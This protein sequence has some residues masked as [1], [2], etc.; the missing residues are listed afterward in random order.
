MRERMANQSE[1]QV[2]LSTLLNE[3]IKGDPT[4]K[5]HFLVLF[6]KGS[7][8][9]SQTP[10]IGEIYFNCVWPKP[11]NNQTMSGWRELVAEIQDASI[12]IVF[13]NQVFYK[14]QAV[15]PMFFQKMRGWLYDMHN[16]GQY[17]CKEH[18]R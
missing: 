2:T 12:S 17:A 16:R 1:K 8:P 15:H 14:F 18:L 3:W 13:A 4:L 10:R 5:K 7:S 11:P 6:G 9:Y